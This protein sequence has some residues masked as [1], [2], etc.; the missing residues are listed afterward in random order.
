[1]SDK[2]ADFNYFL[3]QLIKVGAKIESHYFQLPVAGRKNPRF[4]ERVYC[5]ELYHQL[6]LTLCDQFPYKL[7]GEV[8]KGGNPI[9]RQELGPIKPDFLVHVPGGMNNLVAIEVKPVT[10]RLDRIKDDL[11]KLKGFLE[12]AKYYRA[13]MLIYG[14][15]NKNSENKLK[16]VRTEIDSLPEKYSERILLIWHKE[17]GKPAAVI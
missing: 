10:A 11:K 5:Y 14:N 13:I 7:N 3:E 12:K 15:D 4:L 16:R 1:M 9:I 17:L 8:D 6:R 2:T